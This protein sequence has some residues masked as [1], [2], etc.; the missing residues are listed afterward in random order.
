QLAVGYLAIAVHTSV[1]AHSLK[2]LVA[3]IKSNP[4]KVSYG[5]VGVGSTNHLTGELFKS[6]AAVPDLAQI[7]YRGAGLVLNDLIGGQIPVGMVGSTPQG[8]GFH[9]GGSRRFW[10]GTS[11]A[12]SRAARE[13]PPAA[14][15][16]SPE[17]AN[18]SAYGFLAPAGTPRPMIDK[19]ANATR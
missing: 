15:A 6:I 5:H 8:V 19:I 14:K 13:L 18:P 11:P 2:E 10:A 7:P 1:P 4:G 3:Y 12:P 17:V 9:K 16:G